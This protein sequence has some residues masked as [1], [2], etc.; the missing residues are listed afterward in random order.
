[1]QTYTP[2]KG[3]CTLYTDRRIC[4]RSTDA[5]G[6]QLLDVPNRCWSEEVLEK[7]D[8]DINMLAKVYESPEITGYITPE[9]AERTGLSTKTCVVGGPGDMLPL[10]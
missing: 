10:P 5:S 4:N 1:M 6:M 2:S 7:L 8:I 9:M 3:L